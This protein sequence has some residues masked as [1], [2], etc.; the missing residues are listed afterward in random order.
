LSQH[1]RDK[2]NKDRKCHRKEIVVVADRTTKTQPC[3]RVTHLEHFEKAL[4]APC[5]FHGE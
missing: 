1:H 5:L 4:E 3:E 2:R